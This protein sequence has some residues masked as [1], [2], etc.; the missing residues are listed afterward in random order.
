MTLCTYLRRNEE[1][2]WKGTR[3]FDNCNKGKLLR[4]EVK[5]LRNL[6]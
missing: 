5:R 4:Y 2:C 6:N 3:I 1:D